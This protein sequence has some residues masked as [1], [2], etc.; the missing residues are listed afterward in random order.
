MAMALWLCGVMVTANNNIAPTHTGWL[1]ETLRV[2]M[3]TT[4]LLW[5]IAESD[6][7]IVV[8]GFALG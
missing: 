4:I 7:T 8:R 5:N 1:F 2:F 3:I 6:I